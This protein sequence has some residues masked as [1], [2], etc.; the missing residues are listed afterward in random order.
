MVLEFSKKYHHM[1]SVSQHSDN[2]ISCIART[3]K[4]A[5]G[6]ASTS[7]ALGARVSQNGKKIDAWF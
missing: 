6:L 5:D 1:E 3:K 7:R 4:A 2:H